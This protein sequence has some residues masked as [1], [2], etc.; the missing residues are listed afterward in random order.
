MK[1]LFMVAALVAMT[2]S[3]AGAA[4]DGSNPDW[5]I[6]WD[7]DGP[8]DVGDPLH[9][10]QYAQVEAGDTLTLH[11]V[12]NF[13]TGDWTQVHAY[14]SAFWYDTNV[15]ENYP[16]PNYTYSWMNQMANPA[17]ADFV[18]NG[19]VQLYNYMYTGSMQSVWE[20]PAGAPFVLL[21]WDLK[22]ADSAPIG[23]STIPMRWRSY[24]I[25]GGQIGAHYIE[26]DPVF[27]IEVVPGG[28]PP[29]VST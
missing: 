1:R 29:A 20:E 7:P 28:G 19:Y 17:T 3:L 15:V 25:G 9:Y 2:T 23:T 21:S 5:L 22:I 8:A 13:N 24:T 16:L 6:Y 10:D 18:A 12:V 4:I 14:H 26:H 27:T 11:V